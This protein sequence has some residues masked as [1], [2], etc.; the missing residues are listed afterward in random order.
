MRK[1]FVALYLV[2]ILVAID[3]GTKFW[4]LETMKGFWGAIP[5]FPGVSLRLF[6]NPG[7]SFGLFAGSPWP[8]TLVTAAMTAALAVWFACSKSDREPLAIGCIMAGAASNLID[9][10]L[11]GAVTDFLSFGSLDAPLFTNNLADIWI[12][13]GVILLFGGAFLGRRGT[14]P[15]ARSERP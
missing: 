4:A 9:R 14:S 13:L 3:L 11:N 15:L 7:I 8:V 10:L 6:S 5:L 12:T 2:P 1:A